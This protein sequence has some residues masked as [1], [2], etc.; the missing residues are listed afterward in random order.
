MELGLGLAI[1]TFPQIDESEVGIAHGLVG[2]ELD[3]LLELRF[4]LWQLVRLQVGQTPCSGRDGR[5]AAGDAVASRRCAPASRC[6][7]P[8][9]HTQVSARAHSVSSPSA[10]GKITRATYADKCARDARVLCSPRG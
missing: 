5:G 10:P 7:Q 3:D 9:D 6:Q 2:G 1:A 4:G 8:S